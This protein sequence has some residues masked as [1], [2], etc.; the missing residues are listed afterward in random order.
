MVWKMIVISSVIIQIYQLGASSRCKQLQEG[1][2]EDE[3]EEARRRRR[4]RAEKKK[5]K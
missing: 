4:R 3:E 5:K 2:E 1:K